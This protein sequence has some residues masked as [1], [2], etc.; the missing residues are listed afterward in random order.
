MRFM[1]SMVL[2]FSV[3]ISFAQPPSTEA[4]MKTAEKEA[5]A[6]GKNIFVIFHAS[7]CIWCHRMDT[8]M[9][10]GAMKPLFEKNY[11]I[12]HLT[13]LESDKKKNMENPGAEAMMEKYQ[14]KDQG[15]PFWIV[16]DKNGKYLANSRMQKED[17]APGDNTGC[18]ATDKEVDYFIQVLKKTSSLNQSQL[19]QIKARFLKIGS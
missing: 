8:A 14:G 17:G 7:W 6:S 13:V 5:Q 4:V 16:F 10:E 9:N 12:K 3:N 19:D 18:P 11:V 15:I 1:F 2:I